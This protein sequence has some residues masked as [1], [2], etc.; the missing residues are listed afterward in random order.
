MT[1]SRVLKSVAL[2]VASLGLGLAGLGCAGSGRG[3]VP[4]DAHE[5]GSGR[6]KVSATAVR[7]G[8]VWVLDETANKLV[9]SGDVR[10]DDRIVVDP[11]ANKIIVGGDTKAE[12]ALSSDHRFIIYDR[13]DRR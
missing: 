1:L 6:G 13:P 12:H 10:R 11:G 3:A 7:S 2:T 8:E 4:T 5:L 9:W